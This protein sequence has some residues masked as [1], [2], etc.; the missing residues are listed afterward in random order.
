VITLVLLLLIFMKFVIHLVYV[1][2]QISAKTLVNGI[3]NTK[4]FNFISK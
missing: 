2:Y 1:Q 3:H 4:N